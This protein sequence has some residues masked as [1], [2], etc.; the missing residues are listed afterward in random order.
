MATKTGYTK[1][2]PSSMALE[3]IFSAMTSQLARKCVTTLVALVVFL[4][5]AKFAVRNGPLLGIGRLVGVAKKDLVK[6]FK[7]LQGQLR[8]LRTAVATNDRVVSPGI[9][10]PFDGDDGWGK[11]TF[12]TRK[13]VGKSSYIQYDFD[14]PDQEYILPLQLGQKL[15][16]CFLDENN[17]VQKADFYVSSGRNTK[18]YFSL[19]APL[20]QVEQ[21][22]GKAN[23]MFV[24]VVCHSFLWNSLVFSHFIF[25]FK[26]MLG[27]AQR[28]PPWRR[29]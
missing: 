4:I 20:E 8:R 13:F 11:C 28:S 7:L 9:P 18:G 3:V 19:V 24:S 2:P 16:L 29:K 1:V 22:I 14:L 12:R 23:A 21:S 15:T 17:R 5:L 26:R 6:L 10:M 27:L 25:S